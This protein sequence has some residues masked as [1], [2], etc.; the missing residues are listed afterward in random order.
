MQPIRLVE[1]PRRAER[2]RPGE[3]RRVVSTRVAGAREVIVAP[4]ETLLVIAQRH[5]VSVSSLVSE[6]RLSDL[7]V[8]PGTHLVIPR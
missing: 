5:R 7:N 4:G 2:V 8:H 3:A 6:N 1:A